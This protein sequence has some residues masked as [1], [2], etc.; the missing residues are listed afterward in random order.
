MVDNTLSLFDVDI[1]ELLGIWISWEVAD[2]DVVLE[3]TEGFELVDKVVFNGIVEGTDGGIT[4]DKR[5]DA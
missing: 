4:V 2:N 3:E 1:S 5:S